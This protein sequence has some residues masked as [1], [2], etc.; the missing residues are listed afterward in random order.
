[1]CSSRQCPR[2]LRSQRRQISTTGESQSERERGGQ[3]Q[4]GRSGRHSRRAGRLWQSGR[5][6]E[7]R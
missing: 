3:D 5:Q 7:G 1:M 6:G 2:F 4:A